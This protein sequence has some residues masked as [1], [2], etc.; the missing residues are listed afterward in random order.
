MVLEKRQI[1]YS[2]GRQEG[3]KEGRMEAGKRGGRKKQ[4]KG[5]MDLNQEVG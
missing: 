4:E 1:F 2:Y 3:R 5:R